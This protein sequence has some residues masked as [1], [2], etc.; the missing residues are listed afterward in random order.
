MNQERLKEVFGDCKRAGTSKCRLNSSYETVSLSNFFV[1]DDEDQE[2]VNILI[3]KGEAQLIVNN[4]NKE[5]ICLVK[6][7]KCLFSDEHKKCDCIL[8]S[9]NKVFLVEIKSSA[10]GNRG[11]KRRE[12]VIQLGYTIQLLK[13]NSITLDAHET[14][15]VICFKSG[16]IRP[17]QPSLNSQRAVFLEK[18]NI[19]LEEGN[20]II[21]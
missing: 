19:S 21:F 11:S 13:D 10:P 8:F 6:T 4:E 17:T 7:D 2:P 20:E 14:K 12:A 15:A 3:D 16:Q 1:F 18:H 9:N 5:D